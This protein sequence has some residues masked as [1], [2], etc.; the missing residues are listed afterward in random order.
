MKIKGF[1][2][3]D[4]PSVLDDSP[5]VS[6]VT[7]KS[8][9]V[10]TGDMAQ[11]WIIRYDIDPV[12]ASKL[13]LDESI[14]GTCPHKQNHNGSCYVNIGQAPLAVFKGY[15][16]GLYPVFDPELHGHL[17]RYRK[18]RLG[19][20]GDPAAV[21]YAYNAEVVSYCKA[22]TGYTHQINHKNFD[23]R[24]ADLCMISADSPKQAKK[25]Q[26]QGFRTFRVSN[27]DDTLYAN[28]IP[29]AA[30]SGGVQCIDCGLC[31]GA[32]NAPSIV[33]AVHGSRSKN[34]KTSNIQVLEIA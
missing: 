3:Y 8:G 6:I 34:F 15:K 30:D 32:L 24:M 17:L 28:E 23:S 18:V 22:H 20:Y 33:I 7:L 29:C 5:I 11:Q 13:R 31:D 25:Y 14:C 21:P 10:K 12:K 1:I 27:A 19:A 2:L 4:G 9:N 16:R 26:G